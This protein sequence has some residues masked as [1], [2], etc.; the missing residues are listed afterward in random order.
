MFYDM[1]VY[2]FEESCAIVRFHLHFDERH[3]NQPDRFQNKAMPIF[4]A[5]NILQVDM[6]KSIHVYDIH[7]DWAPFPHYSMQQS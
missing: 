7:P 4:V 3:L 2:W 6:T 5:N 1:H